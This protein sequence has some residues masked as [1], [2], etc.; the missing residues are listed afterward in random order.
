MSCKKTEYLCLNERNLSGTLR[1]QG[2]EVEKVEEFKYLRSTVQRI[3]M[4]R[5]HVDSLLV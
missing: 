3:K 2:P 1:S 5:K 4:K